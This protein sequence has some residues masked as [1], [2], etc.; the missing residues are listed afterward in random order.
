VRVIKWRS[1]VREVHE[2]CKENGKATRFWWESLRGK[3]HCGDPGQYE[4]NF[5]IDFQ[6]VGCGVM[7][8][9]ELASGRYRWWALVNAVMKIRVL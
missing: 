2:A 9:M 5:K 3:E 6:E 8:W 7:A 1:R 4:G